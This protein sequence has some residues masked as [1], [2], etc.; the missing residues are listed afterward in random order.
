MLIASFLARRSFWGYNAACFVNGLFCGSVPVTLA[1]ASD[2]HPSRSGKD[3][4]IGALI[5]INMIGM[6]GGGIIAIFMENEGLFTPLLVGAAI[7]AVA[8]IFIVFFMVDAEEKY[9]FHEV[10]DED[11][12]DAPERINQ[13]VFWNG[14]LLDNIGSSGLF[15]MTL[16]PLAFDTF[17][18][19]LLVQGKE[20]IM[21]KVAFKWLSVMVA[22][23]VI[24]GAALSQPVF[25]RIGPAGGCVFGNAITAG[26]IVACILIAGISPP[27][28]GSYA[29]MP[30][31]LVELWSVS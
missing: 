27:T 6:T 17:F 7:N 10:V 29:G 26:G 14:A 18:V 2:V 16:A 11:D 22:L 8:A 15:P 13:R 31:L 23:M 19:D 1:Y 3:A 5:G 4:E 9:V 30:L 12:L 24:P 20:P 21:T 28:R 25:H